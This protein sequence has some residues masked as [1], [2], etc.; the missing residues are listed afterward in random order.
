MRYSKA[1]VMVSARVSSFSA[2]RTASS[3]CLIS[4]AGLR[5]SA[6]WLAGIRVLSGQDPLCAL[7]TPQ[8]VLAAAVQAHLLATCAARA[9]QLLAAHALRRL[10][11]FARRHRQPGGCVHLKTIIVLISI[12]QAC[13]SSGQRLTC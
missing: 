13:F 4:L 8:P 11:A 6:G 10:F 9:E 7:R 3:Y 12:C 2:T 5:R 1:A